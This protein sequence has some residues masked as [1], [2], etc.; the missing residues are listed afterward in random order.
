MKRIVINA[1]ARKESNTYKIFEELVR[2]KGWTDED[3]EMVNL[4]EENIPYVDEEMLG[5]RS[6]S[7]VSKKGLIEK[8]FVEQ[9]EN[10]DQVI[11]IYPTWNWNVPA[12]LKAYIDLIVI[13]NRTFTMKG[14]GT[15]GLTKVDQA[16]VINTTGGPA[17]PKPIAYLFNINTDIFFMQNMMKILGVKNVVK[18]RLG[19]FGFKYTGKDELL[20]TDIEKI[21]KK[22]LN[23]IK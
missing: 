23:S 4:Y 1:C 10:C 17:V 3:F 5:E 7:Y 15:L 2:Q 8:R 20:K 11:F 19:S 16:V 18:V 13:S 6:N 22:N 14:I 9:F 12:I 21:I